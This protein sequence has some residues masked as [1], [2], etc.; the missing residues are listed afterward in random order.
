[1]TFIHTVDPVVLFYGF[2]SRHGLDREYDG[3]DITPGSEDDHRA[4]LGFAVNERL[5]LSTAVTGIY[6]TDPS[7]DQTQIPGLAMEP[8]TLRF[9]A[10][11]ARPCDRLI[12]PFVELGLTPD[13]PNGGSA[14]RL[15]TKVLRQN[16][17][18]DCSCGAGVPPC[19]KTRAGRLHHKE[20]VSAAKAVPEE[21][22]H[23]ANL[24][25]PMLDD[26][27]RRR[28]RGG[29]PGRDGGRMLAGADPRSRPRVPKLRLELV[30]TATENI[31][32]RT[33]EYS[34]RGGIG[35]HRAPILLG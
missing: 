31:V 29:R 8:I 2:G 3:F 9:A 27:V 4:G 33:H 10:T 32:M 6:V 18:T 26:L 14:S 30:G 20:Q 17:L 19:V 22:S 21:C 25:T 11:L 15:L 13:A 35:R 16:N 7:L 5:T 24:P 12:E 34:V 23:A 1:M 28:G